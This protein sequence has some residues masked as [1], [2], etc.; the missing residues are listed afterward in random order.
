MAW[1]RT[2]GGKPEEEKSVTAGT[3][4]ITVNPSQGK[5]MKKVTVSPT[6]TQSKPVTPS[7]TQQTVEPDS[8]KHLASVIVNG[9][10]NLKAENIKK[11]VTIF[12]KTGIVTPVEFEETGPK[13]LWSFTVHTKWVAAVAVDASGSGADRPCRRIG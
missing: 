10:A 11:D 2:G 13:E 1:Y 6:P 4:E 7:E 5:T 9:D 12:G 3:S 8:G